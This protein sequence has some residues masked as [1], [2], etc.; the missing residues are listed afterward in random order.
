MNAQARASSLAIN[1]VGTD[2][3]TDI[4]DKLKLGAGQVAADQASGPAK[5]WTG[6]QPGQSTATP[7]GP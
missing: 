5:P 6:I 2:A 7:D 4:F 3:L 1:A